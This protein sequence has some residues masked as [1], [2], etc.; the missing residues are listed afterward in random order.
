MTEK[1]HAPDSLSLVAKSPPKREEH[2][3]ESSKPTNESVFSPQE[4]QLNW[5]KYAGIVGCTTWLGASPGIM[6]SLNKGENITS[7][8]MPPKKYVPP[9]PQ[10]FKS[11]TPLTTLSKQTLVKFIAKGAGYGL[12]AG[13]AIAGGIYLYDKYKTG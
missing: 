5:K 7:W 10:N 6:V 4:K 9:K 1:V 13:L 11:L 2:L 3:D 12:L 8:V